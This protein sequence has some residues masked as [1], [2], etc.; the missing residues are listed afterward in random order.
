[1]EQVLKQAGDNLTRENVMKEAA[2][3][4]LE[5]DMM[6]PGIKIQTGPNDFFPIEAMMPVEFNGEKFTSLGKV[7]SVN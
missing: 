4:D 7:V 2:N 3:L 6:L 1:M 5:L